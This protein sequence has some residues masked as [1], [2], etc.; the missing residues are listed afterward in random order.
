MWHL[1]QTH[2]KH[3]YVIYQVSRRKIPSQPEILFFK[4]FIWDTSMA[5]FT[6]IG[7][8]LR[9]VTFIL[10]AYCCSCNKVLTA[11]Y[12]LQ[13][14]V[15]FIYH[16]SYSAY[17]TCSLQFFWF[18]YP[19]IYHGSFYPFG[20]IFSMGLVVLVDVSVWASKNSSLLI[21][22]LKSARF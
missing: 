10:I 13:S 1:S 3:I 18:P 22:A 7:N 6:L 11:L 15:S 9:I 21:M 4:I 2:N 19:Q 12:H 16:L 8:A 17:S 5:I 14:L 20:A